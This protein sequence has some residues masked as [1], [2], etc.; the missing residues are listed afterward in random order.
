MKATR[1]EYQHETLMHLLLVGLSSLSYLRNRVHIVWALVRNH[2][3]SG[4]W[5]PNFFLDSARLCSS[6]RRYWR[7]GQMRDPGF[8]GTRR[9][10]AR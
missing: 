5:E 9:A 6:G 4:S 8:R 7:L 1:F 3:D 2:S 10:A